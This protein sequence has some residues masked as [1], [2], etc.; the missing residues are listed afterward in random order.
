MVHYTVTR[1]YPY[2]VYDTIKEARKV[3]YEVVM[4]DKIPES[5]IFKG[6]EGMNDSMMYARVYSTPFP[7]GYRGTPFMAV[8]KDTKMTAIIEYTNNPNKRGARY[9]LYKDGSVGRRY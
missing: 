5:D 8:D 6:Y 1:K 2:K 9:V 7:S 4:K 3:A